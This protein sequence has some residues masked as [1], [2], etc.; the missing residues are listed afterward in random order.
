MISRP[1]SLTALA[2]LA[3]LCTGCDKP[4]TLPTSENAKARTAAVPAGTLRLRPESEP[5]ITIE[6]I[7]PQAYAGTISAPGRVD[8]RAKAMSSAG[9]V[10]AGRVVDVDVQVGDRVKAGQPLAKLASVDAAQMRSDFNRAKAE[11]AKAEGHWN[12]Q[13]EM[14]R[15]GV[16]LEV[17][18]MEAD[19]QLRTARADF[20]RSRDDLRLLGE[21]VAEQVI[22]RAPMDATVLRSHA[23]VGAAIEA[24]AAL[25]DLGEPSALWV[26][27][28]VFE[29][30]LAL[31]EKGAEASVEITSLSQPL[32]G[33]VVAESA[34]IDP[35][36]RRA[37]VF[38]SPDAV[39]P[40]LK[41]GMFARVSIQ[42]ASPNSIVLPT[43]AVLLKNGSETIVYVQT[44]DHLF[45]S[46]KVLV[47]PSRD[48]KVPVMEGLSGGEKVVTSG[49]L[50]LDTEAAMLL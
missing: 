7:Q 36:S 40:L 50:L 47:G 49:A 37:S 23:S 9:T 12:R 6:T 42:A 31:V 25:F 35:E 18:R 13:Q 48:G 41:P 20:D 8:F 46:R 44:G 26:V 24:G 5:F 19:A 39:N 4:T 28:E 17:E 14:Q 30:D 22:V 2:C 34:A 29:K 21:G 38:I 15:T 1:I 10:V 45:T 11:L 27:A 16:G 32:T 33:H 43:T 3:M